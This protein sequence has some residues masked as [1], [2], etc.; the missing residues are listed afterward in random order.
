MIATEAKYHLKCLS[1]LQRRAGILL[2]PND[3]SE[4]EKIHALCFGELVSYI[5]SYLENSAP[6]FAM[7]DVTKMFKGRLKQTGA[8]SVPVHSTRL[9]KRLLNTI[10]DLISS[11]KG[12]EYVLCFDRDVGRAMETACTYDSDAL[13]LVKVAN[14]I[15]RE[16]AKVENTFN[17]Y[18]QDG[19]QNAS[20][21]LLLQSFIGMVINGRGV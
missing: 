1:G 3:T 2:A 20:V 13:D 10:P 21:P 15:R 18:F 12:K 9:R 4:L 6:M 19:C 11:F 5:E 17:G 14:L 16:L 7:S 8:E